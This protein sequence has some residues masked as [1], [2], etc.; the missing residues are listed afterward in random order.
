MRFTSHQ[1]PVTLRFDRLGLLFLLLLIS[2]IALDLAV[3]SQPMRITVSF[4]DGTPASCIGL[5]RD[6]VIADLSTV[7]SAV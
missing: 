3:R 1:A 4:A 6:D 7:L 2:G 5:V